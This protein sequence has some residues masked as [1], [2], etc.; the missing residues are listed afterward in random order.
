M[1]IAE[2]NIHAQ[3]Q[4]KDRVVFFDVDGVLTYINSYDH[5]NECGL[6]PSRIALL[7]MIVDKTGAKLVCISS[8]KGYEINGKRWQPSIYRRLVEALAVQGLEIA[9]ETI[10]VPPKVREKYAAKQEP[11]PPFSFENIEK[12]IQEV[13][14]P[15]Y[16]RVREVYNWLQ[17]HPEVERFIILDDEDHEWSFFGYDHFWIQPDYFDPDGGLK[18]W[19]VEKAIELLLSTKPMMFVWPDADVTKETQ[20]ENVRDRGKEFEK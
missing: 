2:H 1:T 16:C 7:K 8:W 14:E 12:Y 13:Y 5:D 9:D 4:S 18:P 17:A 20:T 6:E 19:H 11:L 15:G 3:E 10:Y